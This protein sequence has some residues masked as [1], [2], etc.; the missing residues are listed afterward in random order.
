[1]NVERA[2][3]RYREVRAILHQEGRVL[4]PGEVA[5]L[6]RVDP[7]TVTRWAAA[8]K[9]RSIKTPGGQHRFST[10][11]IRKRLEEMGQ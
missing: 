5:I 9:L 7:K 10:D 8:G 3:A 11:E 6:F 1:V 2:E 4:T